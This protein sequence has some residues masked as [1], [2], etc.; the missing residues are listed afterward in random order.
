MRTLTRLYPDRISAAVHVVGGGEVL[1][2]ASEVEVWL[3]KSYAAVDL[4]GL[5][6]QN[7]KLF[8]A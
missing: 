4:A 3:A 6:N 7:R 2:H 1:S 8:L 5:C